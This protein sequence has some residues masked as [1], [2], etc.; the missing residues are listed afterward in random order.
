MP[1]YRIVV[2][3]NVSPEA[4]AREPRSINAG[5][6]ETIV[7]SATSLV[8]ALLQTNTQF[9]RENR[10]PRV[11][12]AEEIFDLND[13]T[14]TDDVI[15][16]ALTGGDSDQRILDPDDYEGLV[17][18]TEDDFEQTVNDVAE[19]LRQSGLVPGLHLS[20]LMN[21]E[22]WCDYTMVEIYDTASGTYRSVGREPQHLILDRDLAGWEAIL[23]IAR[24]L[25]EVVASESLL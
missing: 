5:H 1:R 18:Y 21:S 13:D 9:D 12:S 3:P 25:I 10:S 7:V 23:S 2:Q 8:D 19:A 15:T 14:I 11:V 17:L 6:L 20:L 4:K 24:A 22:G 16:D